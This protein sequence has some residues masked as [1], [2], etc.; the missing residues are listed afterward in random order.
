[1]FKSQS[2]SELNTEYKLIKNRMVTA[3]GS[4]DADAIIYAFEKSKSALKMMKVLSIMLM[5]V[6][7]LTFIFGI[8]IPLLLAGG[9]FFWTH[10]KSMKK[11][12]YFIEKAKNDPDLNQG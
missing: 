8:G 1:M 4:N 3:T 11:Y 9:Y 5:V 12:N 2:E 6:G 10:K 7:V